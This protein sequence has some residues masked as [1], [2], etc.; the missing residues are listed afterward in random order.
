MLACAACACGSG[1]R[2]AAGGR[3]PTDR[4]IGRALRQFGAPALFEAANTTDVDVLPTVFLSA[5]VITRE[6][7]KLG[8][9]AKA[10]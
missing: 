2:F 10:R 3:V 7:L 9:R 6:G 4:L 1:G 5:A 8:L